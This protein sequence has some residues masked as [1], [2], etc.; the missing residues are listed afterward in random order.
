MINLKP[1]FKFNLIVI[2]VLFLVLLTEFFFMDDKVRN[3]RLVQLKIDFLPN[4]NPELCG[5]LSD[6]AG[7]DVIIND[8]HYQSNFLEYIGNSG[9]YQ[10]YQYDDKNLKFVNNTYNIY[11]DLNKQKY[12]HD[13]GINYRKY[14]TIY[15]Y[16]D[17]EDQ[18]V[19]ELYDNLSIFLS[20]FRNYAINVYQDKI[21]NR[22]NIVKNQ[23]NQIEELTDN[24][25]LVDDFD[26]FFKNATKK[27]DILSLYKKLN[28]SEIIFENFDFKKI[29]YDDEGNKI[30]IR[31][32]VSI[33]TLIVKYLFA[34]VILNIIFLVIYGRKFFR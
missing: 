26:N 15:L 20:D 24:R 4:T 33:Q 10:K 31:K 2:P 18:S 25:E 19:E 11:R 21:N 12:N 8:F 22:L 14:N 32:I 16:V 17:N 23:K 1:L 30:E 3:K 34:L 29:V 28:C 5:Y 6:V 7:L 27:R 13:I 9:E